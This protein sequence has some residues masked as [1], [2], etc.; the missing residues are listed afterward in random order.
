MK[1]NGNPKL[2]L[3]QPSPHKPGGASNRLWLLAFVSFFTFVILLTLITTREIPLSS[4]SSPSILPSLSTDVVDALIHYSSSS[5]VT[6]RMPPH[7]LRAVANA[8]RLCSP[9]N[10]LIFG[11]GH[12][13]PL[14]RSINHNGRTVFLDEN[15]YYIA[16]LEER[17][18]NLEAYDVQYTTKVSQMWELLASAREQIRNDCRPVQNLLFSDCG[19]GI[20]D[21]PNQLYDVN[22][23]VILVDG[24]RSYNPSAPGRMS[25]IFTAGVLAR[26]KKGGRSTTHVFVHDYDREVERVCSEEFLCRE[27]MVGKIGLLAH[28]VLERMDANT[29]EFCRN[30]TSSASS[31]SASSS[32]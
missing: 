5:N 27:N 8:L 28:F 17:H 31:S 6:G 32:T 2:I 1:F 7:E 15:Q 29:F 26:S 25:A 13:T 19:L 18:P 9:C 10:F 22:W 14:W 16:M 21:L 20:N 4:S 11:L 3:F 23:D 24:P 12:E 30:H